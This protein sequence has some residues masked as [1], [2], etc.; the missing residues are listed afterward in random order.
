MSKIINSKKQA[1]FINFT[2]KD[3]TGYWDGKATLLKAGEEYTMDD[4]LARHYA[5]HL[6]NREL[7]STTATG[8]LIHKDGDK[9]TSPKHPKEVPA[10]WT[11]YKKAYISQEE[12]NA[13]VEEKIE[14]ETKIDK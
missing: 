13:E 11:R 7:L 3:F 4:Y 6:A 5:K 1:K 9:F 12:M 8:K 14:E 2:N 10:F